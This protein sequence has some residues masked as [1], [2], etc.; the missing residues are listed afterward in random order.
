[1]NKFRASYTVLN[2]WS[3]GNWQ[4]AL[5]QYFRLGDFVTPAMADGR[6]YHKKWAKYI[7]ENKKLPVEFG[8]KKLS[9]PVTEQKKIVTIHEWLDLSFIIDCYDGHTLYEFKTGKSSSESY[10]SS[11]QIP[12]YALGATYDEIFVKDAEIHHFDQY[13]KTHDMSMI[14]ITDKMLKDAYNWIV[15]FSG[16]MQ[17]YCLVNGLYE[18]FGKARKWGGTNGKNA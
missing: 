16:E 15:T 7:D 17:N 6:K 14:W 12:V 1:M 3:S 5:E 2:T 4:R 9:N 18:R 13:K 8:G 11:M 10:A